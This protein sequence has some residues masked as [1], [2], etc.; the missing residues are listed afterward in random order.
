MKEPVAWGVGT[1]IK[2]QTPEGLQA[3]IITAS[4]KSS[5]DGNQKRHASMGKGWAVD[6]FMVTM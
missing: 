1:K 6:A 3:T 4:I 5:L 2:P